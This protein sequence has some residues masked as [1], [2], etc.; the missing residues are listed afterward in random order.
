M[1]KR[2]IVI[3]SIAVLVVGATI[4]ALARGHQGP[5]ERRHDGGPQEMVEHI[6]REL[7]LTDAQKEQVKAILEAQHA[8]EEER[9]AKL[10]DIRKQ[11]DAA[12]ANGQFDEAQVRPLANQ[13]AQLMTDQMVD[14]LRMHSKIYGLLTAEQR[15]KADQLMKQHGERRHGFGPGHGPPPPSE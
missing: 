8:T 9:H 2:I 4:F 15:T 12:T 13:Q 3:A 10:D 7:N 6:S 14:H 11:I 5:G 1:K